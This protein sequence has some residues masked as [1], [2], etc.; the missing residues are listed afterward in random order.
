MPRAVWLR[1]AARRTLETLDHR[2]EHLAQVTMT[3]AILYNT[4]K[5]ILFRIRRSKLSTYSEVRVGFGISQIILITNSLLL[6]P[7]PLPLFFFSP[8]C[9][10]I[11]RWTFASKEAWLKICSIW[12][13][14]R[15]LK[16]RMWFQCLDL[17][18]LLR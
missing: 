8:V 14:F 5:H 3:T 6:I 17:N 10:R 11:P 13:A 12:P 2:S 15:F 7:S 16:G 4:H 18:L 9:T 1:R